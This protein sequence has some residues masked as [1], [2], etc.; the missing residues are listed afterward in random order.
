MAKK[1]DSN[2]SL[3]Q[4]KTD[5]RGKTLQRLY[6][7]Y[8]EE[9]FLLQHYLGQIKRVLIDE[10][11]ESFNYHRLT[12]ET[13]SMQAFADAVE[14]LPMMAEFTMV[15]VDEVD[16]FKLPEGER[17]KLI[18]VLSDIPEYCTVVFSFETTPWKPDKRLKR[19][20]ETISAHGSVIEFP[21]QELRDLIAW[22]GRHFL[23]RNKQI[24]TELCSYLIEI[25]GGT[26]TALSGEIDKICAYSG[27]D[28]IMKADIDAVTEP[29]L[30]AVV[31]RMTDQLSRGQYA[32]ALESL[33]KLIKMQEEPLGILGNIGTQFRRI[34]AA[35]ILQEQGRGA[36]D[37]MQLY[38]MGE[39]PA[40]KAMEAARR[41][42]S[43]FC[44]KAV[45][46]TVETDYA[47]KTSYDDPKRLLE[48][49][50]LK[51]AQEAKNG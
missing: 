2:S 26:M 33:Q 46:W 6:F 30:D 23:S 13:F 39:Y 5:L 32:Q 10:L 16:P 37:L 21:K 28:V 35:K 41:F 48:K 45:Q 31:F 25:T 11:T 50:V 27:A 51:L 4:L 42:S 38:A 15:H 49:L 24:S 34:S 36:G 12:S 43:S 9:V 3:Q 8:G 47:M 20:Y 17:D 1:T 14:N 44:S 7:F 22:V 40:K 18:E 29:V 19:L